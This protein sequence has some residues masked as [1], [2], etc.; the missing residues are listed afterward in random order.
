MEIK[1]KELSSSEGK[2]VQ[3]VE[4]QLLSEHEQKIGAEEVNEAQTESV[5]ENEAKE[6]E[7]ESAST[8][9]LSEEDVLS[10]IKNRYQKEISSID[11]LVSERENEN[12]PEDIAKYMQ[13]RNE[14]G[15][16][17][18]D[19]MKLNEDIDN[20][21]SD[22]LLRQYL[23]QTQDGLDDEDIDVIME[24]FSYDEELDDDSTI[25]KAKLEKK[26]K[27]AEAKKY[28][29]SQ[30]EKYKVPLESSTASIDPKE[31]ED[32]EAYRR[33]VAEA[34]TIEEESERKRNW[35]VE[36]TNDVFND[37]FKGFEFKINDSVLTFKPGDAAELKNS[38]LNPSNFIQKYLDDSG[39][40]KDA[41]GYHK[42]L[43]IAMNPERFA[44][45]FYEQGAAA[46][47][48][49]VNKKIKNIDMS[50]RRT[51]EIASKNGVQV[52]TVNPDS[53]RGLKIRSRNKN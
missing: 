4:Q 26:K 14:T 2:S 38:Q 46:A 35:F 36:K 30:K 18:S 34:K 6:V 51:P 19:F 20:M 32:L 48:E 1:V 52:R 27:I 43:A 3:E 11:D 10:F 7:Q 33:Y 12:L 5:Q 53:G 8:P 45:F 39:M 29:T 24:D 41:V 13:Y 50:E 37:E 42:S 9:E 31:K 17:F 28:F 40:I 25:K 15:R 23:K 49:D 16:S 21:D 44:K 22:D 47:T